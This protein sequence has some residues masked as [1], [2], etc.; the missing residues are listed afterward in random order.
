ME[1]VKCPFCG[2]E[3]ENDSFYCD[4]CG[5]E[6]KLCP[7]H[8]FK[9]GSKVCGQC[10]AALVLAKDAANNQP[11]PPA[12]SSAP[13]PSAAPAVGTATAPVSAPPQPT[14]TPPQPVV[15]PLQTTAVGQQPPSV[16]QP[17]TPENT[18]R[19]SAAPAE[20]KCLV[21]AALNAR[22][23]LKN[24]AVVG[25]RTGDYVHVFGSQGYVSGTHARV[26]VNTVGAWEIVDLDSSNGTFLNGQKLAAHQPAV[27]R[28]GDT[29]AFYDLKFVVSE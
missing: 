4:Q 21:C 1:L 22:L 10:G 14:V 15:T 3:I 28:L 8:G 12:P 17:A 23:E 5:E 13:M 16:A 7:V 18:V 25:R 29:I 6:L 2:K 27:F 20:P 26:Q 9:K 19:P 11:L 24:G